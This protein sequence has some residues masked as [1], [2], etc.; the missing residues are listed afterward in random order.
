M[1]KTRITP[2]LWFDHQAE[3]AAQFYTSIFKNSKIG[4]ISRYGD[5]GPGPKGSVMVIEFELDGQPFTGLNGGPMFK[6][7]EAISLVV[8]CEGQSE[9]DYYWDKLTAGGGAPVQCGWLK[10]KYGLSWQVVPTEAIAM[11]SDKDTVKAQRAMGAVMKMVKL[12]I[13]QMRQAFE[14]G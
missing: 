10:D 9:V 4:T 2:M 3:E 7:T 13:A 1:I 12:D 11:L 14:H 6:F 5:S 8:N